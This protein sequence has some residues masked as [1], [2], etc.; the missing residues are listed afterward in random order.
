MSLYLSISQPSSASTPL[1]FSFFFFLSL[2]DRDSG[3]HDHASISFNTTYH[4]VD[5]YTTTPSQ[6][7]H[8][9]LLARINPGNDPSEWPPHP[10][11]VINVEHHCSGE[12][13]RAEFPTSNIYPNAVLPLPP[14]P[15]H[16]LQPLLSSLR[17]YSFPL[18]EWMSA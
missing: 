10:L 15:P 7:Q 14:I 2:M 17:L 5:G 6:W 4:Q 16:H 12:N 13:R 8:S 9:R 1:L 3:A 18:P 11:C